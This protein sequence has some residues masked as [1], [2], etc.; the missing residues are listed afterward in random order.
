MNYLNITNI[1]DDS[2]AQFKV[3]LRRKTRFKVM[4]S[5]KQLSIEDD[6]NTVNSLKIGGTNGFTITYTGSK[7]VFSANSGASPLT[8][9]EPNLGGI[10]SCPYYYCH[11]DKFSGASAAMASVA[12]T[13]A[14]SVS[15]L[16]ASNESSTMTASVQNVSAAPMSVSIE[17]TSIEEDNNTDNGSSLPDASNLPDGTMMIVQGGRWT[18]ITKDDLVSEIATI[19]KSELGV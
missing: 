6:A 16:S 15:L 12:T 7:I 10:P 8:V 19:V 5:G 3:G 18:E 13:S 14:A 11:Q 17:D 1:H 2:Q 4:N 9:V